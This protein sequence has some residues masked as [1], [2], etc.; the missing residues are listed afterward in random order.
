MTVIG[1]GQGWGAKIVRTGQKLESVVHIVERHT[2]D[3]D[4]EHLIG[5]SDVVFFAAP[6]TEIPQILRAVRELLRN[7]CVLDCATNKGAFTDDLLSLSDEASVCSTH[8]M[9][10]SE[11]PSRGQNALIMPVGGNSQ[12]AT[13]VAEALFSKL[14]MRLYR[15]EFAHHGDLAIVQQ[16]PHLMQRVMIDTMGTILQEKGLKI[17][18]LHDV[19]PANFRM[20]ELGMGRVAIQRPDVSAGI[21]A[22]SLQSE[23]GQRILEI[24]KQSLEKVLSLSTDRNGLVQ[25]FTKAANELDSSGDWRKQ[26]EGSTDMQIE[27][28][29]NFD[30]ISLEL[31]IDMDKPGLLTEIGSVFSSCGL[32]MNAIHSHS[33]E[34]EHGGIGVRFNIGVDELGTRWEQLEQACKE[35][36]WKLS[37]TK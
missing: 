5:N 30:I 3:S 31:E 32:N 36:G 15:F 6:D 9:V 29:G 16:L 21:I 24:M 12:K 2:T 13:D 27:A 22:A 25:E 4:R 1:G 8:P 28:M 26:M 14:Q 34:R 23:L 33:L 17:A 10:R 35:R 18:D 19:A 11:T 7:K 20:T 37:R